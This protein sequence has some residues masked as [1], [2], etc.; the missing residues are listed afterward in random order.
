MY[1]V[2]GEP[3]FDSGN[4]SNDL[5]LNGDKG[6]CDDGS[7]DGDSDRGVRNGSDVDGL[8][9]DGKL[10]S[11]GI[12]GGNSENNVVV[13]LV[14]MPVIFLGRPG[15]LCIK[16]CC[17]FSRFLCCLPINTLLCPISADANMPVIT[18]PACAV[19]MCI[20]AIVTRKY[21]PYGYLY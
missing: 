14:V 13:N 15:G 2:L 7:N 6:F 8:N 17:F 12:L 19:A 16:A 4:D 9:S 5:L 20:I 10:D 21:M 18:V 3:Y 1:G 11:N